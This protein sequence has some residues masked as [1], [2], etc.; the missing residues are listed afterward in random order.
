MQYAAWDSAVLKPARLHALH[1]RGCTL[2]ISRIIA[3]P[4]AECAN[5]FISIQQYHRR[6]NSNK[7][8]VGNELMRS[9]DVCLCAVQQSRVHPRQE[10]IRRKSK[11]KHSPCT[12][13][14][15]QLAC[16]AFLQFTYA[17]NANCGLSNGSIAQ[18]QNAQLDCFLH[19]RICQRCDTSR[20]LLV[21]RRRVGVSKSKA[22]HA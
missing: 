6:V 22:K 19:T 1:R 4:R 21:H 16:C 17:K 15:F 8:Y 9:C 7:S 11:C 3:L 10:P 5:A 14:A 12:P 2:F 20:R 18:F 13:N